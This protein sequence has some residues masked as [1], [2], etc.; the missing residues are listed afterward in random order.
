MKGLDKYN[1]EELLGEVER[2]IT[3]CYPGFKISLYFMR[4]KPPLETYGF[5]KIKPENMGKQN[6][7]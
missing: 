6:G 3:L 4:R 2:R 1:N 7:K 5:T